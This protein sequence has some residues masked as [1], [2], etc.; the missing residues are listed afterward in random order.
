MVNII[1]DTESV[2]YLEDILI[3]ENIDRSDLLKQLLRDRWLKL[4]PRQTILERMGGYPEI[5][6]DGPE[7][8]SDRDVRK[9]IIQTQIQAKYQQ[10]QQSPCPPPS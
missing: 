2:Q 4:R 3:Q 1:L 7:D 9:Q 10:S 5:L 6:L 8:L